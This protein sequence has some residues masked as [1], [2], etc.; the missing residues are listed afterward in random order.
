MT[1]AAEFLKR[2]PPTPEKWRGS[3]PSTLTMAGVCRALAIVAGFAL[4]TLE[5]RWY[6]QQGKMDQD[7]LGF[8]ERGTYAVAWLAMAGVFLTAGYAVPAKIARVAGLIIAWAGLAWA[9]VICAVI[10][11]PLRGHEAVGT[12]RI[13]NA[14]LYVF[15]LPA[16]AAGILAWKLPR[17]SESEK[18]LAQA[19]AVAGLFLVWILITLEVQQWF[20]GPKLDLGPGP[21]G[22]M[23]AYSLAWALLGGI[24]LAAGIA[25]KSPAFRWGSLLTIMVTVAKVFIWDLA[26][27]RDMERVLSFAGLGV[28]LM[29]I[30]FVYQ[31]FVFRKAPAEPIAAVAP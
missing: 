23:T 4:L 28:S 30:A 9:V 24:Y 3:Q 14:L 26:D 22:E 12:M 11:N 18:S 1:L 31:R 2:S 13:L 7:G 8:A 21:F 27:L 19:A 17:R 20:R 16:L 5:V 6:F 10:A 15:G 29:A 25:L